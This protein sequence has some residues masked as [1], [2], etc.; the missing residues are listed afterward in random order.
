MSSNGGLDV[1]AGT[2]GD[3]G[4]MSVGTGSS[5]SNGAGGDNSASTAG[6]ASTEGNQSNTIGGK[7]LNTGVDRIPMNQVGVDEGT[8]CIVCHESFESEFDDA[9]DEWV[10]K[11][12]RRVPAGLLHATCWSEEA[13]ALP[14]STSGVSGKK[15]PLDAS[16]SDG[17]GSKRAKNQ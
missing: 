13:A 15:R 12:I 5:L 11:N 2:S 9:S 7:A 3:Q 6:D 16:D 4:G 10:Y 8:V 1:Q 17:P 14:S